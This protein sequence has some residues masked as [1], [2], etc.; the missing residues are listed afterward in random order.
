MSARERIGRQSSVDGSREQ[1]LARLMRAAIAGDERAYG[2]FLRQTARLVRSFAGRRAGQ[3][4]IDPEDIVQETLLAIHTKRHTWR[5]DAP[6]TPWVHAIARYK[7]ADA[8]RRRGRR[9]EV[10]IDAI[11]DTL[12]APASETPGEREIGR[13]LGTL[14]PRQRSVVTTLSIDGC[15]VGEAAQSLGMSKTAVRVAFHRGLASIAR[16][17]G[18]A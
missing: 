18:R 9:Q 16:R 3:S 11:A 10:G 13:A 15:S 7:L 17:F 5:D 1:E 8:F 4:G 2:E 6:V 14:P 12:A